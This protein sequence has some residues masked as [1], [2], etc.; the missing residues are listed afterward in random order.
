MTKKDFIEEIEETLEEE[1]KTNE[2]GGEQD[3][4]ILGWIEALEYVLRIYK[5]EK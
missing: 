3:D 4:C 5:Q 1:K 2:D